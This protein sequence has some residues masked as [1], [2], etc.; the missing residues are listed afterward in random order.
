MSLVVAHR[1]GV[2]SQCLSVHIPRITTSKKHG[3]G[4]KGCTLHRES[5]GWGGIRKRLMLLWQTPGTI[6]RPAAVG[7]AFNK[8]HYGLGLVVGH[9]P[10]SEGTAWQ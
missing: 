5:S 8:M 10:Q 2:S 7:L 9:I 1:S 3:G 6:G 4:C